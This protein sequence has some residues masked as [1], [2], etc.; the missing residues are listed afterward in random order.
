MGV[1]GLE[2]GV[3]V[4]L[5]VL[6]VGVAVQ[7][8]AAARVV[9][10]RAH[11]EGDGLAHRQALDPHAVLVVLERMLRAV[12]QDG[13]D[14]PGD[15]DERAFFAGHESQ[16]GG[17]GIGRLGGIGGARDV[18]GDVD[19]GHLEGG[20][21]VCCFVACQDLHDSYPTVSLNMRVLHGGA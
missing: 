9:G 15:V 4:D 10:E 12:E 20:S 14:L 16:D 8:L 3:E 19:G 11:L 5:A 21:A 1:V 6:G 2:L 7:A 17:D 13:G 18:N